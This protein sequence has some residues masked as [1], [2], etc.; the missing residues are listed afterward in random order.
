[1]NRNLNIILSILSLLALPVFADNN[2]SNQN[3]QTMHFQ[4]MHSGHSNSSAHPNNV[5]THNPVTPIKMP[6]RVF[7]SQPSSNPAFVHHSNPS[8]NQPTHQTSPSNVTQWNSG[9]NHHWEHNNN[10]GQTN[11]SNNSHH[12]EEHHDHWQNNNS[13]PTYL[14]YY[15]TPVY[16]YVPTDDN[17]YF[18]SSS[19]DTETTYTGTTTEMPYTLPTGIWVVASDGNVPDNA[20]LYQTDANNIPN[21]Y[22]RSG[23]NNQTYYGVLIPNDGCYATDQGNSIKFNQ[24]EVLVSE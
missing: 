3:Q 6:N 19:P 12:E 1:M 11:T 15:Q 2:N 14:Y 22:C 16:P 8:M 10:W 21:Y 20:L 7:N 24:Y 13:V 18:Y 4:G 23:Y 5:S 9:G 17:S